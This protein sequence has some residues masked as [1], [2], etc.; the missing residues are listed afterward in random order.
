MGNHGFSYKRSFERKDH[1]E[2]FFEEISEIEIEQEVS[3]GFGESSLSRWFK[4]TG[5]QIPQRYAVKSRGMDIGSIAEREEGWVPYSLRRSF[6]KSR[7]PSHLTV[8]DDSDNKILTLYRPFSFWLSTM[9]VRDSKG[10]LRGVVKE[11]FSPIRAGYELFAGS[12]PE[13]FAFIKAIAVGWRFPIKNR[14]GQTVGEIKKK[15]NGLAKEAL[16]N[17]DAFSVRWSGLDLNQKI[18][19]VAAVISIDYDCFERNI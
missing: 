19:A 1:L 3:G 5:Y 15:W 8:K 4:Y 11:K 6:L 18:A 10:R 14:S 12:Q 7:R 9:F 16:T 13:P 17:V 2:A